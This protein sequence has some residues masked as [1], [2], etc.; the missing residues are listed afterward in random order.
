[1]RLTVQQ[2]LNLCHERQNLYGHLLPNIKAVM[3]FAVPHRGANT[4]YRGLF[5]QRRLHHGQLTFRLKGLQKNSWVFDS[6]S[7]Q[8]VER[9]QP[10]RIVTFLESERLG[11]QL[12]SPRCRVVAV[13][14][15]LGVFFDLIGFGL[16]RGT[17]LC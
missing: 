12:V 14:A 8:F 6:I 2:A 16:D 11:R 1:M 5:A 13:M 15:C 3:F 9:A 7:R 4:A 17:E 10:L